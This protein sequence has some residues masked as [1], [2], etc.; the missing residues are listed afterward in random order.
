MS[1]FPIVTAHVDPISSVQYVMQ[2]LGSSSDT[3]VEAEAEALGPYLQIVLSAESV[4]RESIQALLVAF[5]KRIIDPA[6]CRI[7]LPLCAKALGEVLQDALSTLSMEL[8]KMPSINA[9]ITTSSCTTNVVQLML[10]Y[11]VSACLSLTQSVGLAGLIRA[12]DTHLSNDPTFDFIVQRCLFS[13]FF[14]P[15]LETLLKGVDTLCS[16]GRH[17]TLSA[18]MSASTTPAVRDITT[19]LI[20]HRP[21]DFFH[22]FA[23]GLEIEVYQAS[24]S[25]KPFTLELLAH[26]LTK[27]FPCDVS[28]LSDSWIDPF[29]GYI[30]EH[31]G[32]PTFT[33]AFSTCFFIWVLHFHPIASTDSAQD[34]WLLTLLDRLVTV[35]TMCTR[36]TK[37]FLL[38][39]CTCIAILT[40]AEVAAFSCR[41]VNKPQ[42]ASLGAEINLAAAILMKLVKAIRMFMQ[43]SPAPEPYQLLLIDTALPYIQALILSDK[44]AA[45]MHLHT[46]ADSHTVVNISGSLTSSLASRD[47]LL[48]H[49]ATGNITLQGDPYANQKPDSTL[50]CIQHSVAMENSTSSTPVTIASVSRI[51]HTSLPGLLTEILEQEPI[52]GDLLSTLHKAMPKSLEEAI[53]LLQYPSGQAQSRYY[54]ILALTSLPSVIKNTSQVIIISKARELLDSVLWLDDV[55]TLQTIKGKGA[56]HALKAQS[57]SRAIER[58]PYVVGTTLIESSLQRHK[59]TI[60][61]FMTGLRALTEVARHLT[62]RQTIC[63]LSTLN[64]HSHIFLHKMEL[65]E[66]VFFTLTSLVDVM[67]R[68]PDKHALAC[69]PLCCDSYTGYVVKKVLFSANES[70]SDSITKGEKVFIS[71]LI[72]TCAQSTNALK[73]LLS[74]FSKQN[75]LLEQPAN[76]SSSSPFLLTNLGPVGQT[77]KLF[78]VS[79]KALEL[80]E[81]GCDVSIGSIIHNTNT[82]LVEYQTDYVQFLRG[83]DVIDKVTRIISSESSVDITCRSLLRDVAENILSFFGVKEYSELLL[84]KLN[85]HQ[86]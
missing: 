70:N 5:D 14:A 78:S 64:Q 35:M 15:D 71:A 86:S 31:N 82:K 10:R 38:G 19:H 67:S 29:V 34:I 16:R 50:T 33:V 65:T 76:S 36:A 20:L 40:N 63:L 60:G 83:F 44:D 37:R 66:P 3:A 49:I 53:S 80:S 11:S 75:N 27:R 79:A 85:Y 68:S 6:I 73:L 72:Y 77:F 1:I 57:I 56:W 46:L 7:R 69:T 47:D 22:A 18:A 24:T 81:E 9:N 62:A 58:A 48:L 21:R 13:H 8:E 4:P 23:A 74:E 30:L 54:H 51:A 2:N 84:K 32:T 42:S 59:A 12:L 28:S 41:Q 26:G 55:A 39:L 43:V 25:L 17:V 52:S 61:G 45:A